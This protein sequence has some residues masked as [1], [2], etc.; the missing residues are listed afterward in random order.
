M[1]TPCLCLASL[2]RHGT[3]RSKSERGLRILYLPEFTGRPMSRGEG[4]SPFFFIG[5]GG[6]RLYGF[7][8]FSGAVAGSEAAC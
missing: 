1:F 3:E 6:F 7:L 2:L 5:R 4:F 8:G